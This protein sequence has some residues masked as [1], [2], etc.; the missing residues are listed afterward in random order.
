MQLSAETRWFWKH[1]CPEQIAA[2]FMT[3][4][5][6]PG[7]G[8]QRHDEYLLDPQQIEIGIKKRGSKP[9]VEIKG[10]IE[11]RYRHL[12]SKTPIGPIEIWCKWTSR[13]LSIDRCPTIRIQK[14]RHL[15]R[16][17]V[18]LGNA[19]EIPLDENENSRTV[20]SP[21]DQGFNIELT[22]V[23]VDGNEEFWW[24][25][26]VEAF[27]DLNSVESYV[28]LAQDKL[29]SIGNGILASARWLNYPTWI[30]ESFT[31]AISTRRVS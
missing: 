27:G 21:P 19:I 1:I 23:K 29:A 7:G 16:F 2:W 14:L 25:L 17:S 28:R 15:R 9:G 31:T 13:S 24:T 3:G 22:E 8:R 11:T 5:F 12:D 20:R 18:V 6:P 26:G 4:E 30:S 10:L